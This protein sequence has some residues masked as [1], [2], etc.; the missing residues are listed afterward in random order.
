[1]QIFINM[2]DSP[3][4]KL[5]ERRIIPCTSYPL[6]NKNSAKYDPSCPVMPVINA[7]FCILPFLSYSRFCCGRR[8][9]RQYLLNYAF[10]LIAKNNS[11]CLGKREGFFGFRHIPKQSVSIGQSPV[12][13]LILGSAS[14]VL[15]RRVIASWLLPISKS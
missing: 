14:I 3:V 5:E 2:I 7:F 6:L 13:S 11:V 1:M 12:S 8:H 4:L 10:F 9:R 15:C